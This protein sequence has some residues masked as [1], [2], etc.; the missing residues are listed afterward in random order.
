[1]NKPKFKSK[2]E[3]RTAVELGEE[4]PYEPDKIRFTQ[5]AKSRFY[6]PDFKLR[7]KVYIECKGKWVA[8]DREKHLLIKEQHPELTIYILFQNSNVKLSKHSNTTY[9][10]WATK[11][12]LKW[13]DARYGIPKEWLYADQSSGRDS[14]R[15]SGTSSNS[16]RRGN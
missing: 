7:D 9:G 16:K 12:G 3:E 5:P 1:M 11:H 2:F 6:K 10:D 14:R 13:A 15:P 8:A 4:I